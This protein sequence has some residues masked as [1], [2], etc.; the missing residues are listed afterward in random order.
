MNKKVHEIQP[1]S[2]IVNVLLLK[3]TYKVMSLFNMY[4][5][6]TFYSIST[7]RV[8]KID[9]IFCKLPFIIC[10]AYQLR[11]YSELLMA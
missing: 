3:N 4:V 9:N 7:E 10:A 2:M 6:M 8:P 1:N 11:N 5:Y